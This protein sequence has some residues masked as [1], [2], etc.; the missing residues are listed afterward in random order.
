MTLDFIQ[1]I[2]LA[3]KTVIF[4]YK[5]LNFQGRLKYYELILFL[6]NESELFKF[7]G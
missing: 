3:F 7:V 6:V 2:K 5:L 4:R 1:A